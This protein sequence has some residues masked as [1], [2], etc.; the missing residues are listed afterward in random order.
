[1][2]GYIFLT[3]REIRITSIVLMQVIVGSDFTIGRSM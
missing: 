1:M 3:S 2:E